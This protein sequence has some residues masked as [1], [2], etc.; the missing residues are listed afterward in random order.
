MADDHD[1]IRDD[2][3]T[4]REL[5]ADE[6]R[7]RDFT[8]ENRDIV[9]DEADARSYLTSILRG[10]DDALHGRV[11]PHEEAVRRSEGRRRQTGLDAAE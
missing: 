11:V 2:I 7:L 6:V 9:S 1:G 5:L 10:L 4:F 3:A 8:A